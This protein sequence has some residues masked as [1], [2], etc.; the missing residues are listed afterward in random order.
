[1]RRLSTK[2][3]SMLR[4]VPALALAGSLTSTLCTDTM[5]RVQTQGRLGRPMKPQSVLQVRSPGSAS[6]AVPTVASALPS[7]LLYMLSL[8]H[9]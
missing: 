7:T 6:Q 5:L 3:P 9:I 1:M 4:W 2:L 8:I